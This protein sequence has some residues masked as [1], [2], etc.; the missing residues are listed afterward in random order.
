MNLT[1]FLFQLDLA[2]SQNGSIWSNHFLNSR[3]ARGNTPSP[4]HEHILSPEM[5]DE[6]R[7]AKLWIVD[8]IL[9]SQT[10]IHFIESA[11]SGRL[12]DGTQST[13]PVLNSDDFEL[14]QQPL[15]SWA[16]APFN[17]NGEIPMEQIMISIGSFQDADRLVPISKEL[18]AMK[19]RLWEAVMPLSERRWQDLSL[20]SPNNFHLACRYLCMVIQVF[21][22]LNHPVIKPFLRETYNLIYSHLKTFEDA[23]NIKKA[24]ENEPPVQLAAQWHEYIKSLFN[25]ISNRSHHWVIDHIDRLRGPILEALEA[26][27]VG[28]MPAGGDVYESSSEQERILT[29]MLHDLLENAAQADSAIFLPMDGYLGDDLPLQDSATIVEPNNP[30]V[31]TTISFSANTNVRKADYYRRLKYLSRVEQWF[32]DDYQ[33]RNLRELSSTSRIAQS[34]VL[35]QEKARLEL[36]SQTELADEELWVR[37]AKWYLFEHESNGYGWSYAI[38]RTCYDHSSEEWEEFKTKLEAD[39][40]NWGSELKGVEEFRPI[41]KVHWRDARFL[42]VPDEDIEA[43]KENFKKLAE[44]QDGFPP[45]TSTEIFLVAD[46]PVI[47]SYLKPAPDQG[48]FV[49]AVAA[50]FDPADV[51]EEREAESPGYDGSLRILSSLLWDD[52]GPLLTMQTQYLTELWPL[53]MN[54]PQQVYE[55]PLKRMS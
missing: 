37:D 9:E 24:Q 44:A 20:D 38:Y 30:F 21:H 22:Y 5:S 27:R 15:S 2:M 25:Y 34:Q 33:Q 46:K 41:S 1:Q 48:G 40:S 54:N 45:K 31:E 18:H 8:R 11:T 49:L 53:A 4:I 42:G 16:P 35:A 3:I 32:G 28:Q 12:P 52:V 55:G 13:L 50:D 51:D 47:D 14:M 36:R 29:N 43:L 17:T 10:I 39:L 6:A 23:L 26:S 19:S 7:D